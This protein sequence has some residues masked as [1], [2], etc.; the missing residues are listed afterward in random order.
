VAR[1]RGGTGGAMFLGIVA[2]PTGALR[3]DHVHEAAHTAPLPRRDGRWWDGSHFTV[4]K[5]PLG[6][7]TSTPVSLGIADNAKDSAST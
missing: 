4:P 3:S 5:S 2:C 6:H 7:N 1:A